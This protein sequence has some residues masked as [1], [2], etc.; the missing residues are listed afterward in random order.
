MEGEW[1]WLPE[2]RTWRCRRCFLEMPYRSNDQA[3][4]A[5]STHDRVAHDRAHAE[6]QAFRRV[7]DKELAWLRGTGE[8]T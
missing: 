5:Q 3:G 6:M 2:S 8:L 4:R 7:V 1:T